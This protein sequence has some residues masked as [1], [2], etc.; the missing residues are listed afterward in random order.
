MAT[1]SMTMHELL[2]SIKMTKKKL[3]AIEETSNTSVTMITAAEASADVTEVTATLL[4]NYQTRAALIS[5]LEAYEK[6]RAITN[7]QTMV[8]IGDRDMTVSDAIKEK[9]NIKYK[10]ALLQRMKLELGR[11]QSIAT[12]ENNKLKDKLEKAYPIGSDTTPDGID[13]MTKA[14]DA[15]FEKHKT[16][17]IDPNN[18]AEKIEKLSAEIDTFEASV[19]AALSYI[20]A[21]TTV[22][23]NLAD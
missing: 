20:N 12:A 14:R 11:V 2:V 18:F 15:E 10:K 13:A 21:V 9:E 23:V 19:D 17:V 8:K 1:K 22:T 4:S 7:A 3:Q 5:N 16:V 6:A